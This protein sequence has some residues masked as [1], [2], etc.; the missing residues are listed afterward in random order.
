[1]KMKLFFGGIE[2]DKSL[3]LLMRAEGDGA[4]GDARTFVQPNQIAFGMTY[5]QVLATVQEQGFIEIETP[6]KKNRTAR[7]SAQSV[8]A[9]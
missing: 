8:N 4:I 9:Q 7:Q 2:D 1:M 5:E 6:V 3:C